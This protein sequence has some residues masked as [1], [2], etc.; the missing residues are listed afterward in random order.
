LHSLFCLC[1]RFSLY[2]SLRKRCLFV[3]K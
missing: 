1:S 2:L 3:F